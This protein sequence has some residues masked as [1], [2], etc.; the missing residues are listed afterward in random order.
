MKSSRSNALALNSV[1]FSFF[2][3]R[4]LLLLFESYKEK[5]GGANDFQLAT[6]RQY[7]MSTELQLHRKFMEQTT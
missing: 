2:F 1:F 7:F 6:F 3:F 4:F 5:G